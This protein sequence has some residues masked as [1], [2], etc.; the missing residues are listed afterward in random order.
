M[1]SLNELQNKLS[2][3]SNNLKWDKKNKLPVIK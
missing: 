2:R 1:N 3:N